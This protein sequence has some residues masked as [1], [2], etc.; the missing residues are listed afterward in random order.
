[1][2]IQ[3]PKLI[4][5]VE[6]N[7]SIRQ[8]VQWALEDEGLR[9]VTASDGPEAIE[10]AAHFKPALIL[11]DLGLPLM[12]GVAVS[13]ELRSR[14][15]ASPPILVVSADRAAPDKAARIGALG[16]ITK[17]F[18]LNELV[19]AVL[20]ALDFGECSEHDVDSAA[21]A[22]SPRVSSMARAQIREHA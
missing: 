3:G 21:H 4:L 13:A 16:L 2:S 6:D 5:V 1:V 7:A 9:V 22:S 12:D 10:K 14:Q 17:P 20:G 19:G 8:L 11:L 15:G 18:D